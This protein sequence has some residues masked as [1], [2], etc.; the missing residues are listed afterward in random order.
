MQ[1]PTSSETAHPATR[2][3]SIVLRESRE[4]ESSPLLL[5]RAFAILESFSGNHQEWTLSDLARSLDLPVPTV[6][7][8]LRRLSALGYLVRDETTRRFRLG[9]AAFRLSE[10]V[11]VAGGLRV[12]ALPILRQLSYQTEET[13]LL[14]VLS[15]NRDRSVCIARVEPSRALRL[16]VEPGREL[17]LHAGASQKVLLAFM[18]EQE[19]EILL[20]SKLEKLCKSTITERSTLATELEVTRNRGW[21][22]SYEET[23]IGVWGL[24]VPVVSE[25]GVVCGLGIAGPGSRI[26]DGTFRKGVQSAHEAALSIARELGF[27]VPPV[28]LPSAEFNC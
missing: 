24:A 16:S 2:T 25:S 13:A 7:R 12:I 3:E 18:T 15:P 28:T 20:S 26:T 11:R 5:E 27:T 10:Q 8:I 6:H 21:A 22:R 23:D 19:I 14:T 9:S 17:A 4:R 1:S